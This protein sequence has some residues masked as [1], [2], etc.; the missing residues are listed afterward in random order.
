MK[1]FDLHTHLLPDVDDSRLHLAEME[2]MV[3]KYKDANFKII[4]LT[5]HLYNPYVHT[6]IPL[7]KKRYEV[8][9]EIAS[10]YGIQTTLGS[11]VYVQNQDVIKGIPI[12]LK[13]QLIEFSTKLPCANLV[14]K[15]QALQ[16]SGIQVIIAHVERYPYMKKDSVLF[17]Q[18][19]ATG[20]LIQVNVGGAENGSAIPF[21]ENELAD[22]ISTDNHGDFTFP[23]RYLEQIVEFPYLL[24]RMDKL[25][26][27]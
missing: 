22:L 26:I 27:I 17:K 3:K 21:L 16:S 25:K 18:V 8:F 2:K 10:D 23:E 5:P 11:E 7:I 19:R 12:A 24:E 4:A 14:S 9:S 1:L 13:Y 20:A 15:V 6:D